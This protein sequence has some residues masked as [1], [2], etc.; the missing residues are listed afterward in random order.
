[1]TSLTP[2]HVEFAAAPDAAADA[3]L[4]RAQTG[5][6]EAFCELVCEHEARLFRQAILFCGDATQAEDLAQETL[7]IAWQRLDRFDGRCRLFTWLCG[8]L[9]NLARNA[10][11]KKMPAPLSTLPR[12]ARADADA[13]LAALVDSARSPVEQLQAAER[14]LAIRH[15][16]D[17]LPDI[18]REVIYLRFFV[19]DSLENIANALGCSLGTVKSRLFHALEKLSAMPE[20]G[21]LAMAGPAQNNSSH[22]SL[23]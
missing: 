13:S 15:C 18:H 17:R 1:M 11:R 6:T 10:A 5:D 12:G 14:S 22:E 19:D 7:V 23:P 20:L 9:L 4:Q 21:R 16:L 8:I 2:H 3:L